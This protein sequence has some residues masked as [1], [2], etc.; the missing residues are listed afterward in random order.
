MESGQ[1]HGDTTDG[2]GFL[3]ALDQEA[4][5]WDDRKNM[6]L[7]LGAGGAARAIVDA[8]LSRGFAS[9]IVANRTSA[10]AEALVAQL[11]DD[12]CRALSWVEAK[13]AR[14]D[15]DLLVNTTSAGMRGQPALDFEIAAL[16]DHAVV[17]DIVYIPRDTPL[18]R[19]AKARNLRTVGG[20][21]MLLHQAVPGFERWFGIRP[22]VTSDL[23]ALI[24]ADIATQP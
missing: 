6:A 22:R 2:A 5:R 13:A 16:P 23:R 4:P 17:N 3:G 24:E 1:L 18:L 12:R 14:G 15:A 8:L 10:R 19:A 11:A 20:L 9:V 7:V 21:G